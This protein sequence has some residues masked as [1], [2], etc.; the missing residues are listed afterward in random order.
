MAISK[1]ISA[2]HGAPTG[3]WIDFPSLLPSP[4]RIMAGAVDGDA[5]RFSYPGNA[6]WSGD[7]QSHHCNFNANQY[8]QGKIEMDCGFTCA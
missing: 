4:L 2:L 7:D 1:D 3:Q 6:D 8:D 5:P